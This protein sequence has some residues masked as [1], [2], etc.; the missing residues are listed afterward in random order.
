MNEVEQGPGPTEIADPRL[1][2]EVKRAAIWIGMILLAAGVI[3]LAGPLMLIAGGMVFAVLLDG[4]TRLLGKVLPIARGWRL[5]IVILATFAFLGWVFW[6][7]GTA[8]AGQF[9]ELRD[10]V[11]VQANR[12]LDW[13]SASGFF[14][15]HDFSMVSGQVVGSVGRVTS[16]LGSAVGGLA[17]GVE[18]ELHVGLAA[19]QP[20]VADEHV[21]GGGAARRRLGDELLRR[22]LRRLRRQRDGEDAVAAGAAD[23]A[24]GSER[25]RHLLPRTGRAADDDRPVALQHGVVAEQRMQGDLRGGGRSGAGHGDDDGEDRGELAHPASVRPRL[26]C[27]DAL[28]LPLQGEDRGRDPRRVRRLRSRTLARR[29]R[30]RRVRRVRRR[31]GGQLRAAA[32]ARRRLR[33]VTRP[34]PGDQA[35][36]TLRMR[37]VSAAT[38]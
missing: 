22:R 29:R 8:L 26:S 10:A 2:F 17:A 20:D 23:G 16:I 7:A 11:V 19:A 37:S 34:G 14:P 38:E 28:S 4:G 12:L 25:D 6:Y 27:R 5:A 1:R 3:V 36:S 21:G 33:G 15:Q 9:T 13:A 30:R 24:D 32:G 35:S 18:R 31:A